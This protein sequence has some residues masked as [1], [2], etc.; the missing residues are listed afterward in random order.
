MVSRR[1][2]A[3][4]AAGLLFAGCGGG[5][6]GSDT[7]RLAAAPSVVGDAVVGEPV[8]LD[9]RAENIPA[10]LSGTLGYTWSATG[11]DNQPVALGDAG[12]ARPYFTPTA[13]GSYTVTVSLT[14]TAAAGTATSLPTTLNVTVGTAATIS[15]A[16]ARERIR[17]LAATPLTP[18]PFD[19][20]AP[21]LSVGTGGGGSRIFGSRL[22]SWQRPEFAVNGD[23]R[24][25]GT[26][27]PD[28]L[29][30]TNRAVSTSATAR[31]GTYLTIDFT[32]DAQA[33][34]ILQK[35]L[36]AASR[37]RVWVDNRQATL[38][39]L[40]Y[41]NDG[42]LYLTLVQF[43]TKATRKVRVLVDN[44]FFG[45][46]RVGSQDSVTRTAAGPKLRTMFFGDSVTEG[47]AGVVAP[48][49]YAAR[50]A[51]LLGW[52]EAWLS[53]VGSTGYLAAT[54]PRLTLRQRYASDV[55]AYKPAV[56]VI[57]AGLSDTAFGDAAIQ[58][59]AAALFDLIQADLPETLVFVTPPFATPT[60]VRPGIAAALKAA[61]GTR[62]NFFWVPS[63]E[64]AWINAGNAAQYI[65]GDG[66]HPTAEG[67]EYLAGKMASAIKALVG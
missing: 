39:P 60:R 59:E 38:V 31:T 18:Q 66:T 55:K 16:T 3:G 27:F 50:T 37:L 26:T 51:E 40:I 1:T 64:E 56:L 36:G 12:T 17:T 34:E 22:L 30:G 29:L 2:A 46:I 62:S 21:R 11:P 15:A 44:P 6:V 23:L 8:L 9:V 42:L 41:P 43:T 14:F 33:F 5:G 47:T 13:T 58:A 49:P 10:D 32:T 19:D 35:G 67:I 57:N 20:S 28:A 7:Q 25:A 48:A 52:N 24:T 4:M 63:S 45:G 53:G 61:V 54:S 65:A